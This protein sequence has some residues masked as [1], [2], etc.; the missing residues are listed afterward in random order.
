MIKKLYQLLDKRILL[1][2]MIMLIASP[3]LCGQNTYTIC[4]IYS[5]YLTVYMNNIFLLMTYQFAYRLNVFFQPMVIRLGE[6]AVY[7]W[8][9]VALFLLGA[10]YTLIIYISYAFFFGAIP[11]ES[12][13]I[14]VVFMI[15]N[16]IIM[17]IETTIIY[18]QIGQKKNF[19]YLALPIFVNFLFHILFINLS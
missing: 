2:L 16:F 10:L 7:I 13:Q 14:T 5:H 6:K 18:L 9:Y 11:S 1:L 4:L 17:G 8:T 12:F 19:I 3:T 15:Y